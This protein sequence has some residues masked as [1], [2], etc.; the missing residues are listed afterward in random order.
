[1]ETY[2]WKFHHSTE[3]SMNQ[4]LA[5]HGRSYA[6]QTDNDWKYR[7]YKVGKVESVEASG[8]NVSLYNIT[9]TEVKGKLV[10]RWQ[11]WK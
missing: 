10:H 5:A 8:N 1:M 6:E 7:K 11:N 2:R 9:F 3:I 4:C